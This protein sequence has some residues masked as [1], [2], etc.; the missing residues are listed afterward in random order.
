MQK[1]GAH[2][3]SDTGHVASITHW[4]YHLYQKLTSKYNSMSALLYFWM[5]QDRGQ[6]TLGP[7]PFHKECNS[8][9]EH[10]RADELQ[11]EGGRAHCKALNCQSLT[12]RVSFMT[13][14]GWCN[15]HD[16]F[17]PFLFKGSFNCWIF[18]F[19]YIKGYGP[20]GVENRC[21]LIKEVG[22]K[23]SWGKRMTSWMDED[24][25]KE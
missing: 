11:A 2:L 17:W 18:I 5:S 25:Q 16:T 20:W 13:S 6:V 4:G 7:E 1:E 22:Q 9:S 10:F 24:K 8:G 14:P 15:P 21:T 3:L 23:L 12:R 19:F